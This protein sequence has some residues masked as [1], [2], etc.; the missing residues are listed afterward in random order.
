MTMPDIMFHTSH[1]ARFMQSPSIYAYDMLIDVLKYC[2]VR[3]NTGLTYGGKG[4]IAPIDLKE[5]NM[6]E[7]WSDAS[8]GGSQVAPYG[9]GFIRWNNAAVV[10][11]ARKLKFIPLSTC[12]AE[13][14]AIVSMLKEVVFVVSVLIDMGVDLTG[15]IPCIT[16]SKSAKDVIMNPGVTKH[17]AHFKRWLHWAR[18]RYLNGEIEIY[19]APDEKMMA[20]DKTK[21][22]D[23]NKLFHCRAFQLNAPRD[24]RGGEA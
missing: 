15:K 19:L 2:Y 12:E 21:V 6:P 16:D 5:Q 10:W 11:L 20:D 13:V 18:E 1:L 3:R 14:A 23:R 8:F 24:F 22:V 4:S 7:V 17:T 9:G